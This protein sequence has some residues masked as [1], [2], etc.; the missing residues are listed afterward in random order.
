VQPFVDGQ[1]GR[2]GEL[3]QVIEGDVHGVEAMAS[4][5][6][7]SRSARTGFCV[8]M[9]TTEQYTS[10]T[11]A[12]DRRVRGVNGTSVG[13][14]NKAKP[15]P[16]R[17]RVDVLALALLC[18]CRQT[19]APAGTSRVSEGAPSAPTVRDDWVAIAAPSTIGSIW[20]EDGPGRSERWIDGVY[21]ATVESERWI[22][23]VYRAT[24][25]GDHFELA[26]DIPA[27]PIAYAFP[28]RGSWYF[29]TQGGDVFSAPTFLGPLAD[30]RVS[31]G[32][33]AW[34]SV[35]AVGRV[36]LVDGRDML[37][38][39]DGKGASQLRTP[40]P[41][42]I[43][44]LRI[45]A[46]GQPIANVCSQ[47][48]RIRAD[49]TFEAVVGGDSKQ[50]TAPGS[51]VVPS[52]IYVNKI[53]AWIRAEVRR[54]EGL[55]ADFEGVVALPDGRLVSRKGALPP[56]TQHCT[57][58]QAGLEPLVF[59]SSV[60]ALPRR[61][62]DEDESDQR[63]EQATVFRI[64]GAGHSERWLDARL[65]G[66]RR[67]AAQHVVAGPGP[68]LLLEAY[69]SYEWVHGRTRDSVSSVAFRCAYPGRLT[70]A[71]L[72]GK[73]V[74]LACSQEEK[75]SYSLGDLSSKDEFDRLKLYELT[76]FLPRGVRVD[77]AGLSAE[78]SVLWVTFHDSSHRAAIA[79]GPLGG[80]LRVA[81][82]PANA[83]AVAFAN[84]NR[85]VAIGAHLGEAWFTLDAAAH[86]SKLAFPNLQ[87]DPAAVPLSRSPTCDTVSCWSS[88][89][90]W[91]DRRVLGPQFRP[92]RFIAPARVPANRLE[93]PP[94]S[95]SRA[96]ERSTAGDRC[97]GD[98]P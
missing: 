32:P 53:V 72:S 19:T 22:D 51:E 38:S 75:V 96:A 29:V 47:P 3:E 68:S 84:A 42:R 16:K 85:G 18:A 86:W 62:D 30:V 79:L 94:P 26:T 13:M 39:F 7:Q 55:G 41:G 78:Q 90:S 82:L 93:Q 11:T 70:I 80:E 95:S 50:P 83:R 44:S 71:G 69:S 14:T 81:P 92:T 49:N 43:V 46:D 40:T 74:L 67:I 58:L 60:D 48:Y 59:C 88:G 98:G 6:Q 87:G 1:S 31:V 65:S 97:P 63:G 57:F 54:R 77:G 4:S 45:G 21:R 24:V 36:L 64:D 25:E 52:A 8:D 73:W 9:D 28:F 27:Q 12:P 23:G 89:F 20:F 37:W 34:H 76:M 15:A 10:P 91:L 56:G 17:H 35:E 2:G 66:P 61:T 5:I 33:R